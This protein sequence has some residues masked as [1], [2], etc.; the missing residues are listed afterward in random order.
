MKNDIIVEKMLRYSRI[1]H[2][3]EGVNFKLVWEIIRNDL[4]K[5]QEMLGDCKKI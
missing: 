4:P 1:V 3:Y 2:D 5:L